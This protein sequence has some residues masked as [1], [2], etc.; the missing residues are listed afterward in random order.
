MSRSVKSEN[1]TPRS[2]L[3]VSKYTWTQTE[4]VTFTI[5]CLRRSTHYNSTRLR[6]MED[7]MYFILCW[8][9]FAQSCYMSLTPWR[10]GVVKRQVDCRG[11]CWKHLIMATV[12]VFVVEWKHSKSGGQIL[13]VV[14]LGARCS[15]CPDRNQCKTGL[16]TIEQRQ[17]DHLQAD[18]QMSFSNRS[19][20]WL[21]ELQYYHT[22]RRYVLVEQVKVNPKLCICL[23]PRLT[24]KTNRGVGSM[25]YLAQRVRCFKH[26][27]WLP[28]NQSLKR[29]HRKW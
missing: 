21:A 14:D 17:K 29:I 23:V 24:Q 2:T 27:A 1:N 16:C 6:Q 8:K 3:W 9:Q 13:E 28:F 18:F 26:M 7:A 22:S 15:R 5:G 4:H 25:K 12:W 19:A 11:Y 20:W 10:K